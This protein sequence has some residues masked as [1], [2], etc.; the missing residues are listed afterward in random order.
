MLRHCESRLMYWPNCLV[1]SRKKKH[2]SYLSVLTRGKNLAY[3]SG[4]ES[5]TT[6]DFKQ[7]RSFSCIHKLYSFDMYNRHH[8]ISN[9]SWQEISSFSKIHWLAAP[10]LQFEL[11]VIDSLHDLTNKQRNKVIW[12]MASSFPASL[13]IQLMMWITTVMGMYATSRKSIPSPI[14]HLC[15]RRPRCRKIVVRGMT[16]CS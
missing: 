13:M 8:V 4:H 11:M 2:C 16:Q 3:A 9:A 7:K 15:K 12:Y 14:F 6:C 5:H 10:E 1:F